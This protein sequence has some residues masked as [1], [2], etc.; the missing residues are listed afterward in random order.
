MTGMRR[1]VFA[2]VLLSVA[3]C[4]AS[5][6]AVIGLSGAGVNPAGWFG[7]QKVTLTAGAEHAY[8]LLA[9]KC[10]RGN[11]ASC[12]QLKIVDVAR[13]LDFTAAIGMI[14][15]RSEGD[16]FF[17]GECHQ[18]AHIIGRIAY[19]EFGIRRVVETMPGIC[20]AG[21]IHGAQEEWSDDKSLGDMAEQARTLCD[22]LEQLGAAALVT[23]THGIGH[24][25]EHELGDWVTAAQLCEQ[26]LS[27]WNAANCVSGA[28]M[29]FIDVETEAG[30]LRDDAALRSVYDRCDTFGPL[31]TLEC[32]RA[33]G[34]A[35]MAGKGYDVAS[36]AQLCMAGK[37]AL[38]EECMTGVGSENGYRN[39]A[40]PMNAA[41]VCLT[42]PGSVQ[43][44]CLAGSAWWV[45][46]NLMDAD[47]AKRICAARP[48]GIGPACELIM[49]T[50]DQQASSMRLLENR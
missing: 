2:A 14:K 21:I 40:D 48:E 23:C 6:G 42:L 46:T 33:A 3:V 34:L 29:S 26:H 36:S 25:F 39:A 7:Q 37:T 20:R 45:S 28:V 30:R 38:V 18:V 32:A 24:S 10:V 49:S 8:D 50:A 1:S 44:P 12:E 4:T 47:L 19:A 9:D 15:E 31:G 5:L 17:A 27:N 43:D 11:A 35:I 16:D 13:Q 41:K 22:G